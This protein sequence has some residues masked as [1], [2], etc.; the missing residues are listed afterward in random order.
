[1]SSRSSSSVEGLLAKLNDIGQLV[2][3]EDGVGATYEPGPDCVE[4]LGDLLRLLRRDAADPA[5]AVRQR[6]ADLDYVRSDLAPLLVQAAGD[7][8]LA[9][10][11]LRVLV[12]LVMPPDE[13]R[14]LPAARGA[15]VRALQR[16]RSALARAD[17]VAALVAVLAG[18][19]QRLQVGGAGESAS[20]ADADMV[21]LVLALLRHVLLVPSG[22]AGALSGGGGGSGGGYGSG[23]GGGGGD[24]GEDTAEDTLIAA[25]ADEKLLELLLVAVQ[26]A[27]EHAEWSVMLLDIVYLLYRK[28]TPEGLWDD[29]V[30]ERLAQQDKEQQ[31][32][33]QQQPPLSQPVNK[34]NEFVDVDSILEDA[35]RLAREPEQQQ[36]PSAS[37]PASSSQR[38]SAAAAALVAQMRKERRAAAAKRLGHHTRFARPFEVKEFDRT[39]VVRGGLRADGTLACPVPARQQARARSGTVVARHRLSHLAVGTRAPRAPLET[40]CVLHRYACA[41]VESGYAVLFATL[42]RLLHAADAAER[43]ATPLLPSDRLNRLWLVAFFTAFHLRHEEHRAARDPAHAVDIAPVACSLDLGTL[44]E[45]VEA[46]QLYDAAPAGTAVSRTALATAVLALTGVLR[47]LRAMAARP[48][49]SP[50][51]AETR[52]L[53]VGIATRLFHDPETVLNRVPALIARYNPRTRP[54]EELEALVQCGDVLLDLVHL[55]ALQ[56]GETLLVKTRRGVAAATT[57]THTASEQD[58]DKQA[59]AQG[60]AEDAQNQQKQQ[61]GQQ[62][63]E[64]EAAPKSTETVEQQPQD[65]Q[66]AAESLFG[67]GAEDEQEEQEQE[68]EE[69]EEEEGGGFFSS[70]EDEAGE[71]FESQLKY[72]THLAMYCTNSMISTYALLLSRVDVLAHAPYAALVG[73]LERILADVPGSVGFFWQLPLFAVF[74]R[75]LATDVGARPRVRACALRLRALVVRVLAEFFAAARRDPTLFVRVCAWRTRGANK[76]L[77]GA[78]TA[79]G[80]SSSADAPVVAAVLDTLDMAHTAQYEAEAAAT[81]LTVDQIQQLVEHRPRPDDDDEN[82]GTEQQ[83]QQQQQPRRK[84]LRLVSEDSSSDSESDES[85][86]ELSRILRSTSDDDDD[87]AK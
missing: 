78:R 31:E 43:A 41:F 35:S 80:S 61:Q 14:T 15:L 29:D 11:V 2:V 56:L 4:A 60:G 84:R 9:R 44:A 40:R 10:A 68:Q 17:V 7:A 26:L 76:A 6:L 59:G 39:F 16:H 73:V 13:R 53:A 86:D 33:Q 62:Q 57:A 70:D 52:A 21:G 71:V 87:E 23:S 22:D 81:E 65:P 66:D 5:G 55:V 1:M 63:Q 58:S 18:P 20:I 54:V 49:D 82:D 69:Q 12:V 34:D 51:N 83:Q 37:A 75:V 46:V 32:K 8:A 30:L 27:D 72:A 77:T 50:A 28:Q 42:G 19:L 36:Q 45:I 79:R 3:A 64:E 74:E 25:F 24:A 48:G 85:M 67:N 38:S 47:V